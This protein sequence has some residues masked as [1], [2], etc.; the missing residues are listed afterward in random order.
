MVSGT[1]DFASSIIDT[2]FEMGA[3]ALSRG[4][5][6][7][8]EKMYLAASAEPALRKHRKRF[9]FPLLL[10]L[11]L[12][13]EKQRKLYRAKILYIRALAFYKRHHNDADW[14]VLEIL[15][16]LAR[17]NVKQS[18]YKQAIEFVEEARQ[19]WL[20][21]PV[22]P[23]EAKVESILEE[24]EHIMQHRAPPSCTATVSRFLQEVSGFRR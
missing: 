3:A 17:V 24:I 9:Q 14:Q 19:V 13:R 20:C 18:L 6:N 11:A 4:E 15:C 5:L 2:Y 12:T 23:G 10:Q 7:I 21:Q 16:L 1:P 8:A 22:L